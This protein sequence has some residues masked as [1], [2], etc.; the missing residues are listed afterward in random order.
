MKVIKKESPI[1]N[2]RIILIDDETKNP[3]INW[4]QI[5]NDML[6]GGDIKVAYKS[7]KFSENYLFG[8]TGFGEI[9]YCNNN[10]KFPPQHPQRG[11]VYACPDY[12]SDYYLPISS[13][14]QHLLQLKE[15]AFIEMC[16]HLGAKEIL[17]IEEIENDIKIKID[18][19]VENIPSQYG[20]ISQDLSTAYEKN[21]S[22]S[23]GKSF[24]FPKPI[25]QNST[26]YKSKWIETEPTWRTLQKVRLENKVIEY[27][28]DFK[29]T[30]DMGITGAL[31]SKLSKIGFNIGGSFKKI[32]KVERKYKVLFW[33]SLE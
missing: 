16:A 30:D 26:P 5:G 13:F 25:K 6:S 27:S 15:C 32:K 3:K 21:L 24:F 31:A 33:E 2:R 14:H 7:L 22:L 11:T 18:T 12:E 20:S 29:Y 28:A 8:A 4:K 19:K 17:L 9:E 23:G 10:F 1:Y